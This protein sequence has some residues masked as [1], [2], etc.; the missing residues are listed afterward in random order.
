MACSN[1]IR[2]DEKNR[3]I[4]DTFRVEFCPE[5]GSKEGKYLFWPHFDDINAPRKLVIHT[6]QFS[7]RYMNQEDREWLINEMA[8]VIRKH[9]A[10]LGL[11]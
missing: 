8:S 7:L 1:Y 5:Y 3:E 6:R 11:I 4:Y 10:K 2:N 9:L